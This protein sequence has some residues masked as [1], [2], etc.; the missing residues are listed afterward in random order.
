MYLIPAERYK[1]TGVHFLRVRETGE[2]SVSMK[3]LHKG[4]GVNPIVHEG[5]GGKFSLPSPPD[6]F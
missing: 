4:L 2:I 5:G 3:N 6:F 1:N